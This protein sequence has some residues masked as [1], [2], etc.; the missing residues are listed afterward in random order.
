MARL[1]AL[2]AL[3][4]VAFGI[5]GL[6]VS[7][8]RA[9]AV[10]VGTIRRHL[11]IDCTQPVPPSEENGWKGEVDCSVTVQIPPKLVP[12]LPPTIKLNVV[13]TYT[14]VDQSGRPS[15]GDRLQCAV[16]D[17]PAGF[18]FEIPRNCDPNVP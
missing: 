6:A 12:P 4:A 14:D 7:T 18:H 13:A 15:R 9:S 11:D 2:L 3:V 17:G 10:D 8:E 5:A 1:I 16:I